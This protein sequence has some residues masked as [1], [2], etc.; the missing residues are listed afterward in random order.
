MSLLQKGDI[1]RRSKFISGPEPARAFMIRCVPLPIGI[2][3]AVAGAPLPH[4]S[5]R[6]QARSTKPGCSLHARGRSA[7]PA[8]CAARSLAIPSCRGSAYRA[9]PGFLGFPIMGRGLAP[10]SD[11]S[12]SAQEKG[13]SGGDLEGPIGAY[14]VV[15]SDARNP[16]HFALRVA[17]SCVTRSVR[18][19]FWNEDEFDAAVLLLRALLR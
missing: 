10:P 2:R 5:K 15:V 14:S 9:V 3:G 4:R 16:P 1:L 18:R 17:S 8:V 19:T 12:C 11:R 7:R 6:A 13:P